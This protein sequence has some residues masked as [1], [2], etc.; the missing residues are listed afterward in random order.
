MKITL[1]IS[2]DKIHSIIDAMEHVFRIPTERDEDGKEIPLFTPEQWLRERIR[3][4]I[5]DTVYRSKRAK[6][7]CLAA[8][9]THREDD[10]VTIN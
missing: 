8:A 5:V 9:E 10:I 6:A 3:R 1:M 7:E 2:D 4:F